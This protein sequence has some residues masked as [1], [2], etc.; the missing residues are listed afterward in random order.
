[1]TSISQNTGS[2]ANLQKGF[3]GFKTGFAQNNGVSIAYRIAGEGS[4]VLLLHGW[5]ITGF[6]WR[7]VAPK[8]IEDYRVIV[9]DYRGAG[10]SSMPKEGYDKLSMAR[11]IV[12]LLDHLNIDTVHFVGHDIGMQIGTA[13]AIGYPERLKSLTVIDS[14]IPGKSAY[15]QFI[16]SGEGWHFNF[17][18]NVELATDLTQGRQGRYFQQFYRNL[19]VQPDA[20]TQEERDYYAD[21]FGDRDRLMAGYRIYEAFEDDAVFFGKNLSESGLSVPVMAVGGKASMAKFLDAIGNDVGAQRTRIIEHAGHF[22]PEE[23]PEAL[24]N[25][26]C[27]FWNSL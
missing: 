20:V 24:V 27:S 5:P 9:P 7:R 18:S 15:K 16:S 6:E 21:C 26:L 17:N 2:G 25:E 10:S 22:I 12:A 8:L 14:V 13:F 19:L 3:D 11:D 23:N 4:A 1:M